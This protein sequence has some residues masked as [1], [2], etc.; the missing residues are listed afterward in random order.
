MGW[1]PRWLA[2]SF[3]RGYDQIGTG[4][5]CRISDGT[6]SDAGSIPAA[7][8]KLGTVSHFAKLENRSPSHFVPEEVIPAISFTAIKNLKGI[9]KLRLR[10]GKLRS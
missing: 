6:F 3:R 4:Q 1:C 8:I 10:G 5:V 7:S 9:S 2:G